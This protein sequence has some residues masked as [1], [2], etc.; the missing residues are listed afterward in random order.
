M[1]WT[2]LSLS[3]LALVFAGIGT[4]RGGPVYDAAADFS[5]TNGNPNGVWSYGYFAPGTT[6]PLN[7]YTTTYTNFIGGPGWIAW[8]DPTVGNG[9]VP[10]AFKNTTG[11][12]ETSGTVQ[13]Q[14]G[15]LAEHPGPNNE[16]AVV[17][18]TAPAS[19]TYLINVTFS[20]ADLVGTTT[21]VHV[22]NGGVS[23]FDGNVNGFGNSTTFSETLTLPVNFHIDFEV[24]FG[25]DQNYFFDSTGLSAQISPFQVVP[26]PASLTLLGISAVGLVGYTWR[27]RKQ[28]V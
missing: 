22:L 15:Q 6:T 14:P 20:G 7:L 16:A 12:T 11:V 13:L 27:R 19:G 25:N 21:D 2:S 3:L 17:R 1:R 18:W 23:A 9:T 8:N 5:I 28:T 24:G 10:A 26:E 4:A